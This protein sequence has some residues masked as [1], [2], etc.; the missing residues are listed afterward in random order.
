LLMRRGART[1]HAPRQRRSGGVTFSSVAGLLARQ[2]ALA[3]DAARVFVAD[4]AHGGAGPRHDDVLAVRAV[5]EHGRTLAVDAGPL[6]ASR[7]HLVAV[8][9]RSDPVHAHARPPGRVAGEPLIAHDEAAAAR[10]LAH[11]RRLRA[12]AVDAP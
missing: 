6:L 10:A 8:A 11:D 5:G 7:R 9:T 3:V 2:R 4:G 1:G 12:L